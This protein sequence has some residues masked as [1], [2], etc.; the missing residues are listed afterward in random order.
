MKPD[1]RKLTIENHALYAKMSNYLFEKRLARTDYNRV[2]EDIYNML[3]GA[4]ERGEAAESLF[5]DGYKKFL[6]DVAANCSKQK[7]Y[8]SLLSVVF[9]AL[10]IM[11]VI[12]LFKTFYVH[13]WPENGEQ[14]TGVNAYIKLSGL[15]AA[16]LASAIGSLAAILHHIFS[17]GKQRYYYIS[18]AVLVVV[19]IA[20][21]LGVNAIIKTYYI[22]FN[23]VA[24]AC[25]CAGAAALI[26]LALYAISKR[27]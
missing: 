10:C 22:T 7:W 24:L 25:A 15:L 27:K 14:I 18:V 21:A 16:M 20:L 4:Q 19:A 17:F 12:V 2:L 5:P 8:E 3:I 13:I 26:R 23:W 11:V 1:I 6:D 9:W